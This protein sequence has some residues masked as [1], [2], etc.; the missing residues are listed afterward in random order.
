MPFHNIFSNKKTKKKRPVDSAKILV[1][2]HEKNSLIPSILS[3]LG[4][5]YTFSNLPTGDYIVNDIVIERKTIPDLKSSIINKRILFQFKNMKQYLKR[6]L[7]IEG[8]SNFD[9]YNGIIHENALRGFIL[10]TTLEYKIPII[11]TENEEDSAK[12]LAVLA[13]KTRKASLSLRAKQQFTDEEQKQFILE[14]FPNIGPQTAKKLLAHFK[15]IKNIINADEK[16][17]RKLIG[18]KAEIFSRF[19]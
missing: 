16:D 18:R 4:I 5:E 9:L 7:I 3:K 11:F 13:R 17:L 19:L 2:N 10:S 6:L 15:S 1:D 14:G 8:T 12:Y